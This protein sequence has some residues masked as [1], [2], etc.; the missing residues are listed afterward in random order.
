MKL[1]VANIAIGLQVFSSVVLAEIEE[2]PSSSE[3]AK[4][5]KVEQVYV[6]ATRE[7]ILSYDVPYT[8]HSVDKEAFTQKFVRSLPE[9]LL[10]TPGVLVQKTA[11]GHG[12]P[13]L[14][15]FTGYR[16]LTLIDGIRY[17]NSVYRDGPN[18]Y[19]SLIDFNT[20]E[21]LELL[22]GPASALYGSD[23]I[24]GTLNL[25][26]KSADYHDQSVDKY[27]I[28][29]RQ[30]Y[31]YA[32]AENSHLSRTEI[33][34]GRGGKWGLLLG[35]S[36]KD[37]G[38]VKAA[39]I[40]RLPHTGYDERGIDARFDLDLNDVWSMSLVHQ[41]LEQDDVWRTHST[42]FARS[43][44]GTSVGSD[45]R[46][47]KDQRRTLSYLKLSGSSVNSLFDGITLT[48]SHQSWDENGDRIRGDGRQ[49]LDF[50]DSRM[51][52]L[53][54]QLESDTAYGDFVYGIDYYRDDVDSGRRDLNADGSLDRVRIQGPVGDDSQ[55]DL[56]GAYVQGTFYLSDRLTLT[57][58]SR[59]TYT[60]ASIGRF[61]D[62]NTN[63]SASFSDHWN[64]LVNSLRI[65]Y[66]LNDEATY[67]VW[68]G[69][70]Q[71]FRAPN[72]ADLSRFGRSRS[73]ETEVA[74]TDLEPEDFLTYEIG[75][76]TEQDQFSAT[77]TYYY[78]RISDFITSTPT[79]RIVGGLTEVSK[80]N[81]ASG[82][83]Q[84]IEITADYL[85]GE[86]YKLY[87]NLT[88]LEGELDTFATVGSTTPVTEP[89]SRIMP[90]TS[91]LGL[92]WDSPENKYWFNLS[93]ILVAKA[94]KLST[95]DRGDTQRIPPG[96]TPGYTLVKLA[97]GANINEYLAINL[98]LQ[99]LLNEAYRSH[100][101]GSN[102]PGFG[103]NLGVQLSF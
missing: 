23:A 27:F 64:S 101:S 39:D 7:N 35:Y 43:F 86:G 67:K 75:L 16:T 92:R 85:F 25:Q 54:L 3:L 30:N 71:S 63:Q 17:N 77:A 12:S 98:G 60:A 21:R 42:I 31:R 59:Y 10:E 32:S 57:A 13:F 70:S 37:F 24:G 56:L 87:G 38:D 49:I 83:V 15:G 96:G 36:L 50:F 40:G 44:A 11:N 51:I 93:A 99:N 100:G 79:G 88:W 41:R 9:A 78:T 53:D 18:E 26:T 73:T 66:D 48:L 14:R 76:K 74:A 68:G 95:G 89:L 19:F 47:L 20:L 80:Q 33:S 22:N 69:I 4:Q 6:T 90:L 81:S 55:F 62:P 58:G 103:V 94:D 72:V 28:H 45:L 84:G 82:F 65:A 52:G 97:A 5:N 34:L 2:Q 29:G 102:E 61:E 46:R 1:L 91:T 8:V